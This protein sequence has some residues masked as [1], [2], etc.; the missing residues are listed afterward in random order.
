MKDVFTLFFVG[1]M[2][3]DA[4]SYTFFVQGKKPDPSNQVTLNWWF[5]LVI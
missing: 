5:G 3:Q 4:M 1:L 2:G